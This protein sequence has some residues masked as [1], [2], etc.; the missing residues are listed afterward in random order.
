MAD[1]SKAVGPLATARLVALIKAET[2]K[3]YD[4]TGGKIDGSAEITG[5]VHAGGAVQSDLLLSAPS[6]AVHNGA[7][8]SVHINCSGDNAAG[9]FSLGSDGKSHYSRFAVGTPTGDNDATTKAYVDGRTHDYYDVTVISAADAAQTIDGGIISVRGSAD[10]TVAEIAAA[11]AAGD[12][13]RCIYSGNVMSLVRAEDENYSFAGIGANYGVARSGNITITI[14]STS[15]GDVTLITSAAGEL[16]V[17]DSDASQNGCALVVRDG[18]WMY[19]EDKLIP[20]TPTAN[21]LMS[22]ADKAKLDSMDSVCYDI[23]AQIGAVGTHDS[24]YKYG[25]TVSHTFAEINAAVHAGK[26]PRVLLVNNI[27]N[28]GDTRI[29]CPLSEYD[30]SRSEGGYYFDAPGLVGVSGS[31]RI[32]IDENG[33]TYTCSAGELPAVDANHDGKYLM[34]DGGRWT[35]RRPDAAT[36]TAPGFMSAKDKAKLDGIEEGANKTVVDATLDATSTNPVQNKAVKA[37]LDGKAGTA[38]ATT[39]ANG[40][41]SKADK[42]KLDGIAAGANK[43]TVDAA[44]DAA[45]ENPVQNKAVKAALDSKLSTR[46]GEISAS[47][48]VGQTVSAGGSVS[49]GRTSTDTGIHFEKAASDAGRISHGSDSMT[50]VSP[51][52]RL[53]VAS[54]T[55]DDDAATKG[56]VD[57]SAVRYDA[58]QELEFAQKGQARKNIDAAGVDSPQFQGFLTLSPANETLGSGVGLSPTGSGHNYTLDISDVDEGNPTLLTGVK[59]PTDADTNAATTVEYVKNKI[60]ASGGVDVDNA[61]SATSTNPVQNKVITSALTKK[62]GTTVATKSANGLMSAADKKKLDG[63]ADG[64]NKTVVDAALDAGSANPVQNKAVK[65]AL[66]NK[67]DKTALDAKADKTALDAKLD[68]TGGTLTGNLTGKYITGTWLRSTEASDLG[69]TPGKI[70]VLDDSGWVYYRTPSELFSDLGIANAIKS[71][72]D[73]AIAAAIN[74]AY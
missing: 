35:Y 74:S 42:T 68:K 37:A 28:P 23:Y 56:Y 6:V 62:A 27:D 18:Q 61:L 65:A 63:I 19:S 5:D 10:K 72:V 12:I 46:G 7:G 47:L 43:T 3:K 36:A 16:P 60:A 66:D 70:A 9:I 55:E 71:H 31:G 11:Y 48:E 58:A 41:M 34:I 67:A 29:I 20:A 53:K 73:T 50:G 39:S 25:C 33:A 1:D 57:G 2:A 38:A 32:Y 13:V 17:P 64:A 54:P 51:I 24:V 45:S 44:L 40:L 14:M 22:A 26:T 52:A 15:N 30:T 49:V 21:G 8:A 59:T 69:R 4:K